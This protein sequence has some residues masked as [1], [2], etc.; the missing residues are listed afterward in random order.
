MFEFKSLNNNSEGKGIRK[1]II[2]LKN[3]ALQW[4]WA[5]GVVHGSNYFSIEVRRWNYFL[6]IS[7]VFFQVINFFAKINFKNTGEQLK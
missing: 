2:L 4:D 5:E 6:I 3:N 1:R 7:T